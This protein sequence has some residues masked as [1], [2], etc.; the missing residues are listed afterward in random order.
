MV[1]P[2]RLEVQPLH[3]R[4]EDRKRGQSGSLKREFASRRGSLLCGA[5]MASTGRSR[6]AMETRSVGAKQT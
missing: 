1:E 5:G 4:V 3:C 2:K 6:G